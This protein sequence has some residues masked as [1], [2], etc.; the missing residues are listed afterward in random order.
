[1]RDP[2]PVI[3]L[4]ANVLFTVA[5]NP[6][7]KASLLI[8]LADQGC[9]RI[10]TSTLAVEEARRNLAVKFPAFTNHLEAL[11]GGITVVPSVFGAAC[12]ISLPEKDRVIFLT[13]LKC[14]ATLL[15]TGDMRHFGP[16]MND[17]PRTSGLAIMTIADFFRSS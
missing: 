8:E 11:I 10:I 4:D 3:F 16:F 15:L 2:L 12:P 5:H 1:M 9:W 14:R 7:G 13:A 6:N 17:P